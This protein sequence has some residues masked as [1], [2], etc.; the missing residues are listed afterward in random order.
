MRDMP[1]AM[2]MRCLSQWMERA[3]AGNAM[4]SGPLGVRLVFGLLSGCG[5][6]HGEVGSVEALLSD[7]YSNR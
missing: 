4:A 1:T 7:L 6:L 5:L 3:M 2:T